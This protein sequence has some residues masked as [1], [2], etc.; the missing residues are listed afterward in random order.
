MQTLL[1]KVEKIPVIY[2]VTF[3]FVL[4]LIIYGASFSNGFVWD[5]EEQILNNSVIKTVSN[6]P[7]LFTSSTFNTGGAGLSGWYYKPLMP[8]SFS[9]VFGLFGP[10]AFGFH[11]FDVFLHFLN[12]IFVFL[13]LKRLFK[14]QNIK[15]SKTLSFFLSAIFLVHPANTESV[16]Y[17]SSTQELLYVFFLLTA[18]YFISGKEKK[19]SV[20]KTVFVS[21]AI[22]LSLL[23]KESGVVSIPLVILFTFLFKKRETVLITASSI[24]AFI[25]YLILRFPIAKT[26]FFQHSKI[27]PIANADLTDRLKTVPFEIFSYLRLFFFPK[28]LFVAQHWVI[29]NVSNP[30]FY[31]G[32]SFS[33]LV[34]L[35]IVFILIRL[36]SKLSIFFIGWII[37]S[38]FLLLNIYPLDMTL[39]ERWFYGPM[40]GVLGLI[41]VLIGNLKQ[42]KLVLVLLLFVLLIPIFSVRTFAR[43]F[44]W[45]DNLTLFSS[46][47]KFSHNSFD[48]QNN[49]GV[50][51]FREEK[52]NEAEKHF[53]RSIMLSPDWWTAANNL[54]VIYQRK[55]NTNKAKE[56]YALSIEKGDYY[57][58]YENMAQLKYRTENPESTISFLET[59]LKR[60]P[61][62]EI[63]NKLL[64][65]SYFQTGAIESARIYAEKTFLINNSQ[66][67]YLLLQEINNNLLNNEN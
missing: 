31:I 42:K 36:R 21:F 54:G 40:I 65:I 55:G 61:N 58:A 60:L 24:L 16:A 37:F 26:P 66:E 15:Y 63:L 50:A 20:K 43:T 28:D 12:S 52:P 39:A 51:L 44:D 25:F 41:G 30:R 2:I 14:L 6:I 17:I 3:F 46:D 48:L 23:S 64:A 29:T 45:R 19:L 4:T 47:E 9:F 7:Y 13:I 53:E 10:N 57:L 34:I 32:L 27:I 22:L 62:N 35:F 8:I 18:I 67:N 1:E 38:F 11:L 59:A 5:D 33:V 56:L 49:L